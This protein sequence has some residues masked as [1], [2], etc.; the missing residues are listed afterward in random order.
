M[1]GS[2]HETGYSVR[3]IGTVHSPLK[4]REDCPHQGEE[5]AP[6]AWLEL[7][8]ACAGGLAGITAG[9]E[10]LLFTWLHLAERD[11]L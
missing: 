5:G 1:P 3:I 8:P 6:G 9:S 10:L 2:G 4:N 11:V 7:D